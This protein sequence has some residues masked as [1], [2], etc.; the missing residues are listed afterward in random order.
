MQPWTLMSPAMMGQFPA[1]AL[2][3]RNGLVREGE[4]VAT[5][6]L[7]REELLQLKGTPLPQDAALDELRLKD[8]PTG[9]E[10]KPGQRL[11]P[12]LH[13]AG[14]TQVRFTNGE[15]SVKQ[16]NASKFID[17]GAQTV[18][19]TTGELKLDY[20]RGL[21]TINAPAAQG[22]SGML[23]SV[24]TVET[25][26][27]AIKSDMELGHIVAVALDG[28]PLRTSGK[29]LLQ[30]MSEEKPSGFQTEPAG[31][32]LKRIVNLGTDPWLIKKLEGKVRFL[33]PDAGDLKV[34][35]LD[36]N[37]YPLQ[38]IGTGSEITLRPE[39]LYYLIER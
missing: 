36:L 11:D 3:Y 6:N 25:G 14:R 32:D 10:V 8:V 4:V 9:A 1:A 17:H 5:V 34:T 7:N 18:S 2:I 12:L 37:G 20:G 35:V 24:G 38:Q 21:L 31:A 19:S 15:A 33:R 16:V 29:M 22:I 39:S 13:Y 23:R 27:L 30:V 28:K 26:D